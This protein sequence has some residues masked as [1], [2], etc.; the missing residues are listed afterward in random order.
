M[1]LGNE[2]STLDSFLTGAAMA[3]SFSRG[4]SFTEMHAFVRAVLIFCVFA[5]ASSSHAQQQGGVISGRVTVDGKTSAGVEVILLTD[6]LE[7]RIEVAK[8]LTDAQ[9]RFR[10]N[11]QQAGRYRVVPFAPA[12]VSSNAQSVAKSITVAPGDEITGTDFT[13]V[14]GGIITGQIMTPDGRPAI[15]ERIMLTP[16]VDPGQ[17]QPAL[18]LPPAIF[19][20]DDRGIYRIFGLPPGRYLVSAGMAGQG[21][22][23]GLRGRRVS[24]MRTFHP[25]ATEEAR[26]T[27][28]EV[29]PGGEASNINITMTRRPENFMASGRIVDA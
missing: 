8:T 23:A 15:A 1:N 25:N 26:A 17:T 19:E 10:L 13:L 18:D 7:R 24:Y 28:V 3:G 6:N 9:G 21:V 12:F 20:T 11:V 5:C 22:G 27:P 14:R 2:A 29:A 16:A 4:R